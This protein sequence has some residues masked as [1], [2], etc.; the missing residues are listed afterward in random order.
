MAERLAGGCIGATKLHYPLSEQES[1]RMNRTIRVSLALALVLPSVA[2]CAQRKMNTQDRIE[3]RN[4]RQEDRLDDRQEKIQ[5]K[6][7][8]SDDQ[9][10]IDRLERKEDRLEQKEETLDK[11]DG[12]KD[13]D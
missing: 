1:D 5:D 4:D 3:D 13:P 6:Q 12:L 8:K 2:G 7:N 11:K 9:S 10:E